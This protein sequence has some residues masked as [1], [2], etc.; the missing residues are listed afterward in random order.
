MVA[1]KEIVKHDEHNN[2][3]AVSESLK[4]IIK[5]RA[6]G[7]PSLFEKS[8]RG[9]IHEVPVCLLEVVQDFGILG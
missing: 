3:G 8:I 6:K 9:G 1:T 5:A 4:N 7:G 2:K